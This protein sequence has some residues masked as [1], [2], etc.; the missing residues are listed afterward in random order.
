MRG[1]L[2]PALAV[3]ALVAGGCGSGSGGQTPTPPAPETQDAKPK[4]A[5][6]DTEARPRQRK[7][8]TGPKGTTIE[9]G[10]SQ[11]GEILFDEKGQAIYLFDKETSDRSEC[12][13]DCAAAW[14][15]VLTKGK[16]QAGKGI[17]AGLLGTTKREGGEIQVTYNGHPLYFYANEGPGEVLC[18]NVEGFGGLWLVLDGKGDALD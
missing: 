10:D 11:Y 18:H 13:D 7:E 1:I 2:I 16:P 9:L 4:P 14:P 17:E 6:T 12:Y 3:A 8:P 15:P 5:L